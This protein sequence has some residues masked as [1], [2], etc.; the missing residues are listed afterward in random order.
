MLE[1]VTFAAQ[2]MSSRHCCF[3]FQA[4]YYFCMYY[5][6]ETKDEHNHDTKDIKMPVVPGGQYYI[7]LL[8]SSPD[9]VFGIQIYTINPSSPS[10]NFLVRC[11]P[12]SERPACHFPNKPCGII[13]LPQWPPKWAVS[14]NP[15]KDEYRVWPLLFTLYHLFK[16]FL[17]FMYFVYF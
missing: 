15:L 5:F 4:L 17:L 8:L 14:D 9:T 10:P 7:W 13:S 16:I 6:G 12:V 1:E 2:A 11:P 3:L